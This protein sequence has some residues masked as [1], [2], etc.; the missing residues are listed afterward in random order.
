[1]SAPSVIAFDLSDSTNT[2]LVAHLT[3]A[4]DMRWLDQLSDSGSGSFTIG[5]LDAAAAS[6]VTGG[7]AGARRCSKPI[8]VVSAPRVVTGCSR[9]Y[10][11]RPFLILTDRSTRA[12]WRCRGRDTHAPT[13]EVFAQ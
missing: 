5:A 12:C 6:L 11:S 9:L 13:R 8:H 7:N 3:A 10:C 2:S 4:E 1:M